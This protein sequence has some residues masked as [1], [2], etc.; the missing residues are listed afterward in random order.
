MDVTYYKISEKTSKI[1]NISEVITSVLAIIVLGVLRICTVMFSWW[2]WVDYVLYGLFAIT[3]LGALWS[4]VIEH[5]LFYKTF[6]YGMTDDYLFIKSGIFTISET[7]VPMAKI[8][9]IDLNQGILMRKFNVFSIT[10]TTMKGHHTIPYLE[11]S[12]AKHIREE[13]AKLARLKELDE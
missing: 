4:I 6:R 12:V 5:P 9:S 3:V 8:Q 7:V 13:I 11:E 1:R 2:S 10:V